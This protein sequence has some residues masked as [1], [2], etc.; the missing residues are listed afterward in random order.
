MTRVLVVEPSVTD[1]VGPLGTWLTDAGAELVVVRPQAGDAVPADLRGVDALVVLGG[2]MDAEDDEG[3]PYLP[4]VRSLLAQGVREQVPTLAVCLGA[5][6]LALATG[7]ATRPMPLGPEAGFS[8]VAKRD[9]AAADPLLAELPFTPDVVQFHSDEVHVLPAGSTVLAATEHCPHQAFRVGTAA[10]ALQFHVETDAEV[11]RAWMDAAPAVAALV[12]RSQFEP[13]AL[14]ARHAE[15]AEVWAP[16]AA[17]FVALA[18]GG[19]PGG[20]G[21]VGRPLLEQG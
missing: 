16:V 17:R 2:E 11:L 18:A 19:G 20:G 14:E 1:P 21:L 3:F 12:P 4:A 15:L 6:L 7:G 5:Q 13:G 9:A 8:L 10:W